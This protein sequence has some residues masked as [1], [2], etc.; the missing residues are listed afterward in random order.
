MALKQIDHGTK[1][2]D[3]MI[4]LRYEVLR[5]P[6][7]LQFDPADLAKEQSDILIACIDDD[8]MLGCCVLTPQDPETVRLRQMAVPDK[9]HGKGIGASIIGFAETLARDKGYRCVTMHARDSAMGFYSKF[10][11][12]IKG[13]QFNEVTLPHHIM[14]KKLL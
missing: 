8:E 5:R 14:E 9:L 3:Q 13:D 4:A 1:E 12:R 10:G 7:G 2:Y 6:L 11:Y